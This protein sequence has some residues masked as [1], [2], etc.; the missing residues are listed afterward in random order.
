MA[1]SAINDGSLGTLVG[2]RPKLDI[3]DAVVED[4]VGDR[5]AIAAVRRRLVVIL[6]PN[7][8][9]DY[10]VVTQDTV[11]VEEAGFAYGPSLFAM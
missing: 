4:A 8:V 7:G 6:Q 10:I 3:R 11:G 9:I 2:P 1:E 5:A